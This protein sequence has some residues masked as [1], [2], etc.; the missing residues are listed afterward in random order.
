M[1]SVLMRHVLSFFFGACCALPLHLM[2][3]AFTLSLLMF[4]M[5]SCCAPTVVAKHR[6]N[7]EKAASTL[8]GYITTIV[9]TRQC[10]F[11]NTRNTYSLRKKHRQLTQRTSAI[12]ICNACAF[13]QQPNPI[14]PKSTEN[15]PVR[16]DFEVKKYMNCES[17]KTSI[18]SLSV[19]QWVNN[20]WYKAVKSSFL[21]VQ[22]TFC[23][24]WFYLAA[25]T[26]NKLII[27]CL[28]PLVQACKQLLQKLLVKSLMLKK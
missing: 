10:T 1:Q 28:L 7:C 3:I 19:A 11:I 4:C 23:L 2:F 22:V 21:A 5:H 17:V 18:F 20:Q 6:H 26:P 13:S 25:T 16:A 12:I 9:G 27:R 15:T 8:W 14:H 24:H